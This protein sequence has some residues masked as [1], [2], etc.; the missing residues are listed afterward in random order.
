MTT[1]SRVAFLVFVLLATGSTRAEQPGLHIFQITQGYLYN[2]AV[3]NGGDSHTS[4]GLAFHNKKMAVVWPD[5]SELV[6]TPDGAPARVPNAVFA[7]VEV[8]SPTDLKVGPN[9]VVSK[10]AH[11]R[12]V[13]PFVVI[14][15]LNPNFMSI[16]S[17]N[18]NQ[19]GANRG[20][21]GWRFVS[22]KDSGKSWK[23]H[24]N[25]LS[26][27]YEHDAKAPLPRS[28]FN[29]NDND[30]R[31]DAFGN[32]YFAYE[33]SF[34]VS[35]KAP[36]GTRDNPHFMY[37]AMSTDH[38]DTFRVLQKF[39]PRDIGTTYSLYNFPEL[40]VGDDQVAV[41]ATNYSGS[42]PG[43]PYTA[44]IFIFAVRGLGEFGPPRHV[45]NPNGPA[46]GMGVGSMAFSPSGGLLV[47]H[48]ANGAIDPQTQSAD[49]IFTAFLPKGAEKFP[50]DTKY[51][52]FRNVGVGGQ[53]FYPLQSNR[54]TYI[55]PHIAYVYNEHHRGRVYMT[56][57]D[58]PHVPGWPTPKMDPS[59]GKK[60]PHFPDAVDV[61]SACDPGWADTNV[62]VSYSDDDGKT[63]AEP[64]AMPKQN[65]NTRY[66]Q[67]LSIDQT[68]GN[69]GVAWFSAENDPENIQVQVFATVIPWDFFDTPKSAP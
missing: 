57:L 7:L 13:D 9:I 31:Y 2:P 5:N 68:T 42:D 55:V 58:N 20:S 37:I 69:I 29:L 54:G 63:W 22:S 43:K 67:Q 39:D 15:P 62:Y 14:N 25:L 17:A 12:Q 3:L 36:D 60:C 64:Y 11:S 18:Q 27:D 35:R 30:I 50:D 52:A 53:A 1:H 40:A 56:Y 46:V 44:E 48:T 38:G 61:N 33:A 26:N 32:L 65:S 49:T 23:T 16:L 6:S 66:M 47:V 19:A 45:S 28:Q 59:Y 24:T 34:G 51:Q 41:G 8:K 21:H 10:A 4:F